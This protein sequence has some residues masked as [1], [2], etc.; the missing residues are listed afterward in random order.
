MALIVIDVE[1]RVERDAVEELRHV[2]ERVDGDAD[3]ADLAGGERVIGV[4]ADLRRQIEGHA[5]A[6][7][8]LARAGSGSG[9][10]TPAAVPKPAYC[11]MVHRRPR[12]I[13][14]WMPRVKGNSPGKPTSV[15]L[16]G[17]ARRSA[18]RQK[19]AVG[20]HDRKIT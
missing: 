6:G 13:V 2:L 11:R 4:V 9:G 1:T 19:R 16:G 17:S 20:G 10:S 12:Y 15:A 18:G 5:Q 8:A 3:A 7:D 14:G